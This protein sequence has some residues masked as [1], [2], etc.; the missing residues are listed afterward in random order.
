MNNVSREINKEC[1]ITK[2]KKDLIEWMFLL[3]I[4]QVVLY[5]FILMLLYAKE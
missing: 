4:S 5:A 1:A 3:W 2:F